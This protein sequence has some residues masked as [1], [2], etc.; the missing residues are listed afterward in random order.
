M[1]Q[2]DS[3]RI[4]GTSVYPYAN[5]LIVEL[6]GLD[7]DDDFVVLS[8]QFAYSDDGDT[9]EPKG[10]VE[11]THRTAVERGLSEAGYDWSAGDDG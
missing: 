2:S 7:E 8:Y 11:E 4:T 6:T 9:V 5:E 1:T 10:P 3:P